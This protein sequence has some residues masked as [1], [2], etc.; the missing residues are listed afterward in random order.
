MDVTK[1]LDLG[2]IF[3]AKDLVVV[4][5]GGGTGV[6]K[7]LAKLYIHLHLT[8]ISLPSQALD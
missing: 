6:F 8:N 7:V 3:G 5:T 1:S 4:I 2:N